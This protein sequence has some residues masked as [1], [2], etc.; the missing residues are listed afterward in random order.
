M[1]NA[2]KTR[3][4][5]RTVVQ[6]VKA[7]RTILSDVFKEWNQAQTFFDA[8]YRGG[9]N[10]GLAE[11]EKRENQPEAWKTLHGQALELIEIGEFYRD[12]ADAMQRKLSGEDVDLSAFEPSTEAG[13]VPADTEDAPLPE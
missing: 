5:R 1:P 10:R 4:P 7:A 2:T 11:D 13:I 8:E 3:N 6:A 12:Y 9:V